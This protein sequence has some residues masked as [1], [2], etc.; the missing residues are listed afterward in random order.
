MDTSELLR[1]AWEAVEKSGV[2]EALHD[3]AFREAVEDLRS[4]EAALSESG[5]G[6]QES[7]RTEAVKKRGRRPSL[8][9]GTTGDGDAQAIIDEETFFSQLASESGVAESDL[10]DVFSF[11][12]DGTVAVTTPTKDLGDSIVEQAKNVIALV[13]GARGVG[14][15]ERP[16]DAEVVRTELKRKRCFQSNNFASKH[17]GPMKGFNAGSTR[18]QIVLTSKWIGEFKGGIDQALGRTAKRTN[19]EEK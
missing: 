14:I 11:S 10:R 4:A 5:G 7:G 13:A 18:T 9:K 16:V 19:T 17:L 1:K 6:A 12:A 15:G 8:S 2:P 3:V